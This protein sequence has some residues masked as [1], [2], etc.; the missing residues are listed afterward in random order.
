VHV[1]GA[2]RARQPGRGP[3]VVAVLAWTA[4]HGLAVPWRGGPLA[5]ELPGGEP[6]DLAEQVARSLA[7]QV[8]RVLVEALAR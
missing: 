1:V 5:G 7:E 2:V 4:I 8:A 3:F 6:R